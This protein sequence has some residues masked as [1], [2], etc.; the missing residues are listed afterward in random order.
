MEE[1]A[2][3][4]PASKGA[5]DEQRRDAARL[6]GSVSSERKAAAARANA[7]GESASGKKAGR[8]PGTPQTPETRAKIAE[9]VR[10]RAAERKQ[11]GA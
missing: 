5:T 9:S 6:M 8:R 7:N 10:A 3:T 11:A 1:S 4:S 2:G